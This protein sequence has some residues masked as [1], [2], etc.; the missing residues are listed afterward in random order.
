MDLS[1]TDDEFGAARFK[2]HIAIDAILEEQGLRCLDI[3]FGHAQRDALLPNL[4]TTKK[5]SGSRRI[6]KKGEGGRARAKCT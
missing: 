5:E 2:R 3:G 1:C 4:S 6:D